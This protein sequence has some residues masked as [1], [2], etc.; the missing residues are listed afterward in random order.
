MLP[1][2]MR[3]GFQRYIEERIPLGDSRY[4][5]CIGTI[6][7]NR[8]DAPMISTDMRCSISSAFSTTKRQASAGACPE[9]VERRQQEAWL[10]P[11]PKERELYT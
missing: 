8:L 4:G 10:N 1:E 11:A 3:K 7:V 5:H 2:H 6:C 9:K